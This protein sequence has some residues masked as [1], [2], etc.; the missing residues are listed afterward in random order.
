[1]DDSL[2]GLSGPLLKKYDRPGPR[3]TSYPTAPCFR[4]VAGAERYRHAVEHS[5]GDLLPRPL[6]LYLHIPFCEKLCYYCACNKIITHDHQKADIYLRYLER[7]IKLQAELFDPDRLVSQ[8]HLGGGPFA[9]Q[10][11]TPSLD[12]KLHFLVVGEFRFFS[13]LAIL[14]AGHGEIP[15]FRS[16]SR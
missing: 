4:P 8:I 12:A 5:N 15:L 7:E 1:M 9:K 14:E 3:Y 6:S 10:A 11:I 13:T 2:Y 16:I